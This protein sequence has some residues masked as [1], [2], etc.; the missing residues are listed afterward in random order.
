MG[1]SGRDVFLSKNDFCD[2]KKFCKIT[3]ENF[4]LSSPSNFNRT[5]SSRIDFF[6]DGFWRN[7]ENLG[8]LINIQIR[9]LFT[10]YHCFSFCLHPV[11]FSENCL[12]LAD[13]NINFN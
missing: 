7:P 3:F 13:K 11:H 10:N 5:N 1:R 2:P 8:D 4:I 6:S 9:I 12:R